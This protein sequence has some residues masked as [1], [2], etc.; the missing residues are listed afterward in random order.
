LNINFMILELSDTYAHSCVC[1]QLL[2]KM[3]KLLINCSRITN[4]IL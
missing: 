4:S 1:F 2:G 3:L